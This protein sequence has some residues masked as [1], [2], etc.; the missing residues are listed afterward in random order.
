MEEKTYPDISELLAA[1]QARRRALAA[2]SWEEKVAIMER[3]RRLLP[4]D[5]WTDK[6]AL[7]SE[8]R[9]LKG[10]ADGED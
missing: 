8:G 1:K 3:M 10:A 7:Q 5:A 2:L 4:N 6:N 9:V